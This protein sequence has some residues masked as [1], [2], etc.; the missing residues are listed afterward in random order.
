[1]EI[2]NLVYVERPGVMH[3]IGSYVGIDPAGR[4]AVTPAQWEQFDDG[5]YRATKATG[6]QMRGS[7]KAC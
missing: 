6:Q 1:M 4:E 2:E 5:S 3:L 7:E